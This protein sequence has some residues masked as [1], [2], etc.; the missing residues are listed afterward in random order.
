MLWFVWCIT[1]P[2]TSQVLLTRH[3]FAGRFPGISE[4]HLTT[5]IDFYAR[6][7]EM[8]ITY[9]TAH[10]C[11]PQKGFSQIEHNSLLAAMG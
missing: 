4:K 3:T 11:F 2:S 5:V 6:T 10:C 1:V 7:T 8:Q 9:T